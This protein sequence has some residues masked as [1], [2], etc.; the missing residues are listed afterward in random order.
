MPTPRAATP[1]MPE[2]PG[3]AGERHLDLGCGDAPR[4]PYGRPALYGVDIRAVASDGRF[5]FRS[6][7]LSF[8]PIPYGADAFASVSAFDFIEHVPRVLN[9]AQ[10]NTTVFPFVRL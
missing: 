9:G 6:A 2:L 4:N 3:P 1:H 8:E 7:N 10:P 5:E